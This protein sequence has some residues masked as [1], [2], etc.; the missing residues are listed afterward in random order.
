MLKWDKVVKVVEGEYVHSCSYDSDLRRAD[1]WTFD[2]GLLSA[3][4]V[5]TLPRCE[6]LSRIQYNYRSV[7]PGMDTDEVSVKLECDEDVG[8]QMAYLEKLQSG[9]TEELY[10]AIR[11]KMKT[12][13]ALM[14]RNEQVVSR[15]GSAFSFGE[16]ELSNKSR[17]TE[18]SV[19]HFTPE[20]K[21]EPGTVACTRV[22]TDDVG[23]GGG[24][25]T[26]WQLAG[27]NAVL[28]YVDFVDVLRETSDVR[29]Q[30][31]QLLL[32][33]N[34]PPGLS[35]M[36]RHHIRTVERSFA[37]GFIGVD[38]L[39]YGTGFY[40]TPMSDLFGVDTSHPVA[41]LHNFMAAQGLNWDKESLTGYTPRMLK[42]AIIE[43]SD[44][45]RTVKGV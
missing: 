31:T 3:V 44:R 43:L 14:A 24:V 22:P 35:S 26:V 27:N 25:Y 7:L 29:N 34:N 18:F 1:T 21:V 4:S 6:G 30:R 36:Q 45:Q 19:N 5:H 13:M 15:Y 8:V 23:L 2:A 37:E 12:S 32:S 16:R 40:I 10:L 17:G 41:F 33:H 42:K 20:G 28:T 39:E 38:T 9:Y 11:S